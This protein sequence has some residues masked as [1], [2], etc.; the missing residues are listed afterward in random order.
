MKRVTLNIPDNE[1]EFFAQLLKK[2]KYKEISA[3]SI[4]I[5][6]DIKKLV[7][8]RKKSAIKSDYI[9]SNLLKKKLNKKYGL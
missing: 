8:E 3:Q 1:F 9:D 7:I 4:D 5:P 2:F 6:E